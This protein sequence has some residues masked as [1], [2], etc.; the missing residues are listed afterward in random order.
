MLIPA[1]QKRAQRPDCYPLKGLLISIA[2]CVET[3]FQEGSHHSHNWEDWLT[4]P[5][6]AVQTIWFMLNTCFPFWEAGV[7]VGWTGRVC[8]HDQLP[9]TTPGTESPT[10]IPGCKISH[11]SSQLPAGGIKCV[12]CGFIRRGPWEACAW[13][14]RTSPHAPC[15]FADCLLGPFTVT[16]HSFK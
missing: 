16:N 13:F 1:V 2:W 9:T 4:I 10:N 12:L 11:M 14:S 6:L 3:W 8:P 15:H 5:K 7:W